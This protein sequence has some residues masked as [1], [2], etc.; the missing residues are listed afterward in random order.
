MSGESV[1]SVK[2]IKTYFYSENRCNRAVDGVSFTVERGKTLGIVGESGCGKST[3]GRA[4]LKLHEPTSGKIL[5]AGEDIT[6]QTRQ[7]LTNVK[8]ILEEAGYTL[9]D[10][11]KATVLLADMGDFAPLAMEGKILKLVPRHNVALADFFVDN[12]TGSQ[13]SYPLGELVS[14]RGRFSQRVP[15]LGAEIMYYGE[16]DGA[17]GN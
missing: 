13:N 17:Q 7:S 2:N 14:S 10:V 15:L 12:V 6:T 3:T 11:V 9:S 8:A 5:F 1:I 16:L 4:I